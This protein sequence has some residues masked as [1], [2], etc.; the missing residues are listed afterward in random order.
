MY[1]HDGGL[2]VVSQRVS[3]FEF[4]KEK[5]ELVFNIQLVTPNLQLRWWGATFFR[6][7]DRIY[8]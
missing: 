6:V 5:R 8:A 1:E 2:A 7:N 4:F 3:E